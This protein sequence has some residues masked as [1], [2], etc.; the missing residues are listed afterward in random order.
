MRP[1][2]RPA[3]DYSYFDAPFLA[4]AHR[5][6]AAYP[7]NIGRENTLPAFQAAVDL[8]YRYLETDVHATRD[9]RLVAFHD[10][11][12]DRV[13]DSTGAIAELT[14]DEVRAARIGGDLQIP[15]LA[16]LLEAF[17]GARFNID[18]KADAAAVPL[19][20]EIIDHQV[21]QRVCVSAFNPHRLRRLRRLLPTVPSSVS[22]RAVVQQRFAPFLS[23]VPVL[24]ALIDSPG[25]ALQLPVSTTVAG[26]QVPVVTRSLIA[27]AHRAGRQVHAWTVD[28]SDE[29]NR[30]I[31]LGVDG[32]FTDRIDTLKHVLLD[33]A[34]W[35]A[36]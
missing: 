20:R 27:A 32:I 17:P 1:V 31:D 12:L 11:R 35:S 6:G 8:G 16:E 7:P 2:R 24:G 3:S 36:P 26:V 29:M 5:G 30:L 18:C 9:G 4:F 14:F 19:A 28:D 13:T 25:V 21:T 22:S 33:R 34:L 23:S 15:T 10:D